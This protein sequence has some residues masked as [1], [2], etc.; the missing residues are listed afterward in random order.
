MLRKEMGKNNHIAH[1]YSVFINRRWVIVD[2]FN[3]FISKQQQFI[4]N[5]SPEL[6]LLKTKFSIYR[7]I[8][9]SG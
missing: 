8:W 4:R 7:L 6:I 1:L 5:I 2:S 3:S 9:I